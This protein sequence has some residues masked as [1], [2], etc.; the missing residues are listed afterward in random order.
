MKKL[1]IFMRVDNREAKLRLGLGRFVIFKE[2]VLEL[3]F[4]S[5]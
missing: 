2:T 1:Q 5:R 4:V 3:K